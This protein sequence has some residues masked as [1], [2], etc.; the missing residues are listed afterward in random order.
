MSNANLKLQLQAAL[1]EV[2][3]Q[4]EAVLAYHRD[5]GENPYQMRLPSGEFVLAPYLSAKTQL[6]C[7]LASLETHK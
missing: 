3:L 4:Q 1:T 6:L 2:R 5:N 7:A